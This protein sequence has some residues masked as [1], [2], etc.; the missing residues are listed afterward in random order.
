MCDNPKCDICNEYISFMDKWVL[1]TD[2]FDELDGY[3][4]IR[5]KERKNNNE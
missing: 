1:C 4:L 5:K 2:C 3:E